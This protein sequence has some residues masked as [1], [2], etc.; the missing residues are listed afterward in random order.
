MGLRDLKNNLSVNRSIAP[1]T[2]TATAQGTGVDLQGAKGAL[3]VFD[4]GANSAGT[5]VPSVEESDIG[6][7]SPDQYTAV[8]AADL[9]GTLANISANTIQ[10]V[11]YKG[12]KRYIRAVL[13]TASTPA[14]LVAAAQV[15][16]EPLAKPA[17]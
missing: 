14:S 17:A 11:G 2:K 5:F 9:E 10:R 6:D 13:T 8:A 7:T 12:T 1:G 15:I 3:V 4:P 16:I